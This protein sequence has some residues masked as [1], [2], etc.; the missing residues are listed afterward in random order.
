[1]NSSIINI[2]EFLAEDLA[3]RQNVTRLFK[4]LESDSNTNITLSFKNVKSISRSFAHEY[5]TRKKT[6]K[7]K[8][9]ET[10]MPV[11][12]RKMFDVV[13]K[14]KPSKRTYIE[15]EPEAIWA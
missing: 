15:Q 3:L 13:N 14:A 12:V 2:V 1:M 8:I 6:S 9:T 10:D 11:N 4:R 5:L 7:K